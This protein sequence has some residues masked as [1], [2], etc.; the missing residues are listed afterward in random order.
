MMMNA[1]GDE[2]EE[3]KA[4]IVV[5]FLLLVFYH[6][7][8]DNWISCFCRC[9]IA[10]CG[11]EFKLK[12][13]LARHYAQAHGIAISSGSPRPIMKT[14]TAFYLQTN[15]MTRLARIICRNLIRPKKAARQTSYAI[16]LQ[17][18]KQE[19]M[20]VKKINFFIFF[21]IFLF[22]Y[23][24]MLNFCVFYIFIIFSCVRS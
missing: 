11:K 24:I 22:I 5:I 6:V 19:C 10:N 1:R 18:I 4:Y 12:T 7:I 21:L 23:S 14:R 16:N 8:M 13:H 20:E 15:A 9:S 3:D 17:L 2:E